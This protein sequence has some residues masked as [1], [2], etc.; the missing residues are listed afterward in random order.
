MTKTIIFSIL[1]G[2]VI[3]AGCTLIKQDPSIVVENNKFQADIN[4]YMESCINKPSISVYEN[5]YWRETNSQL[6]GKGMYFLDG[7][8]RGYGMCDLVVCN[9]IEN[10]IEIN[11]VEYVELGKKES[12]ETEGYQVPDYNSKEL[13]GKIRV[14]LDYFTDSDCKNK[15]TFTK[16]VNN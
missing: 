5:G 6:P 9:K 11:L 8:Y 13:T 12:P 14:E 15:K 7:E 16:T 4:G 2:I 10:S 1:I 3:L